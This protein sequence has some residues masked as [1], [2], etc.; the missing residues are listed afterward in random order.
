LIRFQ[1]LPKPPFLFLSV[2]DDGSV[3]HHPQLEFSH[4]LGSMHA[5]G[6]HFAIEE[7]LVM[8]QIRLFAITVRARDDQVAGLV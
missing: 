2:S 3:S 8:G 1:S 7:E 5:V 4:L 6:G